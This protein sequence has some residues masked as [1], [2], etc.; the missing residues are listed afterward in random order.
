MNFSG[1]KCDECGRIKG[2][3]NH[4]HQIGVQKYAVGI[5]VELGYLGAHSQEGDER[6]YEVRDLCG[7][8]CFFLHIGKLLKIN[9]T[10]EA[11]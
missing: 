9:P 10:E 8:R 7:E 11:T 4:W 6:D 2:E 1:V 3:S 5:W